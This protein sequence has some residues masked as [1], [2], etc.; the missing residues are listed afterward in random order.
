ML[1]MIAS[2]AY[3]ITNSQTILERVASFEKAYEDLIGLHAAGKLGAG[4][5]DFSAENLERVKALRT[6]IQSGFDSV[7]SRRSAPAIHALAE[8][9][10]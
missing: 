8:R 9:C 5:A 7:E 6:L 3:V 4:E 1:D 10:A 2:W